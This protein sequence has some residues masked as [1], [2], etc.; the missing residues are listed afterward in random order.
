[1]IVK[2]L[3]MVFSHLTS[4]SYQYKSVFNAQHH[5]CWYTV[6]E[7]FTQCNRP[8][9]DHANTPNKRQRTS[10]SKKWE[11]KAIFM[12]GNIY[13]YSDQAK[14]AQSVSQVQKR[15]AKSALFSTSHVRFVF[16]IKQIFGCILSKQITLCCSL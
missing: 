16:V 5:A 13:G 1:M 2:R 9:V 8:M 11:R 3:L 15:I 4:F 6:L 12:N 14:E 10:E 7:S